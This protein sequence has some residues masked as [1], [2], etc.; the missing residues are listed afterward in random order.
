MS[1]WS[2]VCAWDDI[3]PERGVGV[4]VHGQQVALFRVGDEVYAL[5][6][7]D[8]F[9]GA[10]V[11]ARGIVGSKG[12]QLK[13]ASP[14]YKQTF[15]LRTGRCLEDESVSVPAFAARVRDGRIQV[16]LA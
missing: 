11:I 8:P 3:Q 14:M 9:S 2:D 4:L 10:N 7:R 1:T 5:G 13:V 15:D 12:D 16:A 6:N